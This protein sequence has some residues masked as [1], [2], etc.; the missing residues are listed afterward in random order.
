[1]GKCYYRPYRKKS[2][3]IPSGHH[4]IDVTTRW[5][6]EFLETSQLALDVKEGKSY[7][8][9]AFELEK[10]QDTTTAQGC[11][12][13]PTTNQPTTVEKPS[14]GYEAAKWIAK[15]VGTI[16]ILTFGEFTLPI[17]LGKT[18]YDEYQKDHPPPAST[19]R[20]FDGCCYVWAEDFETREVVAGIRPLGAGQ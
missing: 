8:V 15:S 11:I 10:G 9:F 20:P 5:S 7:V 17:W 13:Q 19:A 3:Q 14:L 2:Y 16:V 1:M 18:I 12:N 6:N 4:T